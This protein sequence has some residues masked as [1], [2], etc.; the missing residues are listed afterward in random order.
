MSYKVTLD[1]TFKRNPHKGLYIALEGIDGSGKTTQIEKLK[2]YFENKEK[3]I[4]TIRFPRREQ[5]ILAEV[6]AY[7][8]KGK[9]SI[10]KT[11]FQFLFSAD[12]AMLEQ[13]TIIPALKDGKILLADRFH[14]WSSLVYGM[15]EAHKN[16]D[17][18]AVQSLMIANGLLSKHVQ[19]II[20]D[21]TFYLSISAQ[22]AFNRVDKKKRK[23]IYEKKEIMQEI[24]RGYEWLI[25][26]FP[27]EFQIINAEKSI[28]EV[29][30]DMVEKIDK[31]TRESKS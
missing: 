4:V 29:T 13:E 31:L 21:M 20:P 14:C 11:T 18:E 26:E 6:N 12:Y 28:D 10:P 9:S 7:I 8:L 1:T 5:G 27:E 15:W 22:K 17:R 23:D 2:K 24:A 25:K 30:S 16:Y 3:E 19:F